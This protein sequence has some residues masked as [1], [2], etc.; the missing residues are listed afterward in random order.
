[1]EPTLVEHLEGELLTLPANIGL[2]C[3]ETTLSIITFSKA[4]L[5]V[6]IKM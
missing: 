3:D 5:S 4:T 6:T 1:M 2:G